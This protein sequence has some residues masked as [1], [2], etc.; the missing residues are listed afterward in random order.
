MP[1]ISQEYLTEEAFFE[2]MGVTR[3]EYNRTPMWKCEQ[4]KRQANLC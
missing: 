2:A 3:A 1:T 4:L